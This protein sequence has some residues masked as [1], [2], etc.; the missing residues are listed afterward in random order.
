MLE[1]TALVALT[2]ALTL[3]SLSHLKYEVPRRP[4]RGSGPRDNASEP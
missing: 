3:R 2:A 4:E 1:K